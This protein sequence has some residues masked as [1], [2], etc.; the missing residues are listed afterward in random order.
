MEF[1]L[2]VIVYDILVHN[3]CTSLNQIHKQV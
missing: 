1:V 3:N 2:C